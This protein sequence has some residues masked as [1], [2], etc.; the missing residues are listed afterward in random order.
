MSDGIERTKAIIQEPFL[1]TRIP[2]RGPKYLDNFPI[3]RST[4]TKVYSNT[5]HRFDVV[6]DMGKSTNLP[7]A[8]PVNGIED[9]V[10]AA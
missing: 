9:A 7:G 8:Q 4:V 3:T 6:R 10:I 5:V 2:R 1:G